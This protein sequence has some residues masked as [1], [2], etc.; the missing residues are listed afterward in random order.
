MVVIVGILGTLER[1]IVGVVH[2]LVLDRDRGG[3]AR[4][5]GCAG[6]R[7]LDDLADEARGGLGQL[8]EGL[9]VREGLGQDGAGGRADGGP[10]HGAEDLGC[11]T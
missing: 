6:A 11:R 1:E 9:S 5:A 3:A 2:V 8:H 7:G 4:C 10:V